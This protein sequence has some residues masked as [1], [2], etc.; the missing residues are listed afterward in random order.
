MMA[1]TASRI[2]KIRLSKGPAIEI[3]EQQ[4]R[5]FE[6]QA[7][8]SICATCVG[9]AFALGGAILWCHGCLA[10]YIEAGM[11]FVPSITVRRI[12]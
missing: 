10:R 8:E 11:A 12:T 7:H 3:R 5:Q 9:R 4:S 6:E 1:A 2:R